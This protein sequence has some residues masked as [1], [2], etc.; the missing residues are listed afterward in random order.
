MTL[1]ASRPHAEPA[2]GGLGGLAHEPL[3]RSA[4]ERHGLGEEDA[5]RVAEGHRLRVYV[6]FG[7][8]WYGYSLRRLQENPAMAGTIAKATAGRVLRLSR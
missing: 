3:A 4:D 5:H 8:H 6:P 7:E 2:E 1:P